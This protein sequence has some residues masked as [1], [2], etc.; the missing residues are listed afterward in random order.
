MLCRFGEGLIRV[1]VSYG[2]GYGIGTHQVP[3]LALDGLEF[4]LA[5]DSKNAFW[6][7]GRGMKSEVQREDIGRT[8]T[9]V[10][11]TVKELVDDLERIVTRSEGKY[12]V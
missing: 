11:K 7:A 4:F 6:G 8:I 3:S 2:V 12:C 1:K 10:I 5:H 9:K